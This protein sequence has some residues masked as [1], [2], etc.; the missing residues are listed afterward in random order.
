MPPSENAPSMG[1]GLSQVRQ[2]HTWFR[3]KEKKKQKEETDLIYESVLKHL[4]ASQVMAVAEKC[5]NQESV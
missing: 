2:S 4:K 3:E 5:Q 1:G